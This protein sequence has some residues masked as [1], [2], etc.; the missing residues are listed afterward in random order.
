MIAV[1]TDVPPWPAATVTGI[2]SL[3]GTDP[4]QA[5]KIVVGELPDLPHLP[6]LP[7]RGLGADLVGRTAGLLV[8]LAVEYLPSGYRVTARPSSEVRRARDHLQ[9]DLDAFEQ[10]LDEAGTRPSLVKTQAAGPWTLTAGVELRTGHRVLTDAG[11]LREFGQSLAEG[12]R[13]HVA[14][15]GRRTGA[16]VVVQLDE[17]A[18]PAVL[19]GALPTPSGYGTVPAVASSEAGSRLRELVDA[20]RAAGAAAVVVHCCAVD[21]PVGVL[22]A[23]GPDALSL[24]VRSLGASSLAGGDTARLD[25]LGEAA[26]GGTALLLGL[27]PAVD[28]VIP[29]EL[30]DLARPA[31]DLVDRLGLARTYLAGPAAVP[32]PTCGL[33]GASPQW[34][35]RA[36]A[37]TRDLGRALV[38]P[39][40]SW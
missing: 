14:E 22:A 13:L 19:G 30:A 5:A 23:A 34:A 9:R 38:E 27:V 12:L 31:L 10:A 4:L 7:A 32:T 35:R 6:E 18:L 24:D 8:D 39:P 36:L 15:L 16:E 26:E 37:L 1:D 2:G 25:E 17:P 33:A 29:P 11:A 3:P 21:P 40:A 28:P 20:T